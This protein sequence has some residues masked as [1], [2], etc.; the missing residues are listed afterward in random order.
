MFLLRALWPLA[1]V[2]SLGFGG[3]T[4]AAVVGIWVFGYAGAAL[5]EQGTR[6]GALLAMSGVAA[7][8]SVVLAVHAWPYV[9]PAACAG[10]AIAAVLVARREDQPLVLAAAALAAAVGYRHGMEK[11]TGQFGFSVPFSSV[12]SLSLGVGMAGLGI[13]AR[14]VPDALV[15]LRERRLPA[16]TVAWVAVAVGCFLWWRAELARAYSADA[17]TFLLLVYYAASGVL[18][19]WRGRVEASQL[20][21]QTGLALSLWAAFVALAGDSGVQQ[22]ALRVGSYLGVGSFLLGVAWWYREGQEPE[23]GGEG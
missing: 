22:I 5:A 4:H 18:V 8:W 16:S 14:L 19:L 13:G 1:P 15:S 20:L 11:V 12:P 23:V 21:R 2:R 10:V 6:R 17:A 7:T 9:M 3:L